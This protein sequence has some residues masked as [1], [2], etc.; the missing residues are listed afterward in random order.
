MNLVNL[1]NMLP[2]NISNFVSLFPFHIIQS[3]VWTSPIASY[4]GI[5]YYVL[6]L[7]NY[8]H[9]VWIYPLRA[10]S[11]VFSKFIHFRA[12]V[13]NQFNADIKQFQ[14]DNGGEY[15]NQQ[16]QNLC[17]THGIKMRFSCPHTSP[18]NG[19]SERMIRTINNVVHTLLFH[20]RL[21]PEY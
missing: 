18:Q 1:G 8:S 21:P 19:K 5:K 13:K 17:D 4:S 6:F 20:A 7:D 11:E 15:N 3:D 9:F 16:F 10:K 14:C 2:F 12:L